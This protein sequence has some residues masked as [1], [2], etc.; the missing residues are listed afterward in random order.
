[1]SDFDKFY[2]VKKV[3]KQAY[4]QA[5]KEAALSGDRGFLAYDLMQQIEYAVE[6]LDADSRADE[7]EV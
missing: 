1:M 6:L 5:E 4:E 2:A 3:L 7:V